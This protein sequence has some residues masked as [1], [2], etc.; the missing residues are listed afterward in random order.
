MRGD[1]VEGSAAVVGGEE[2]VEVEGCEESGADFGCAL[3]EVGLG[4]EL[5]DGAGE[6]GRGRCARRFCEVE[7]G[8]DDVWRPSERAVC[9]L[10]QIG[11][12]GILRKVRKRFSPGFHWRLPT[13]EVVCRPRVAR[14]DAS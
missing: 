4:P 12:L 2:D 10:L 9:G 6:E 1:V 3:N 8:G 7:Q 14:T 5:E 11:L 13:E